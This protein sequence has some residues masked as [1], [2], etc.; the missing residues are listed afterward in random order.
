MM[1]SGGIHDSDAL[2][3]YMKI[4]YVINLN[5]FKYCHHEEFQALYILLSRH[6][7]KLASSTCTMYWSTS[8]DIPSQ[9]YHNVSKNTETASTC[10]FVVVAFMMSFAWECSP[11]YTGTCSSMPRLVSLLSMPMQLDLCRVDV[12]FYENQN[13]MHVTCSKQSVHAVHTWISF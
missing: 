3:F 13:Y 4:I 10:R 9:W 12:L 5:E 6:N 2:F 11:V 8:Q 1:Y 7:D